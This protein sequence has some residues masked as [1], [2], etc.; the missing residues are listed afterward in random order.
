MSNHD[1]PSCV[2]CA[3]RS[4]HNKDVQAKTRVLACRLQVCCCSASYVIGQPS[5]L[6]MVWSIHLSYCKFF[7]QQ[8][9]IMQT[10]NALARKN[11]LPTR[12]SQPGSATLAGTPSPRCTCRAAQISGHIGFHACVRISHKSA[13]HCCDLQVCTPWAAAGWC[14]NRARPPMAPVATRMPMQ[15]T[16]N[17]HA[18]LPGLWLRSTQ[19]SACSNY[20]WCQ[21][22]GASLQTAA[23]GWPCALLASYKGRAQP[24]AAG[25]VHAQ[26][27]TTW[28]AFVKSQFP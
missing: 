16:R 26:Q 2:Q 10:S 28:S 4:A 18:R 22:A 12:C 24:A 13:N 1:A 21:L 7:G 6:R 8:L 25:Y 19:H 3:L 17:L 23:A 11:V 14:Q 9:Y 5:T 20:T 15:R 27:H